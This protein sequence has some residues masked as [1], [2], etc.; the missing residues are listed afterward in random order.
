M[1]HV[2]SA[3]EFAYRHPPQASSAPTSPGIGL[4][5]HVGSGQLVP[6]EFLQSVS[7]PKRDPND[8]QVLRRLDSLNSGYMG[9]AAPHPPP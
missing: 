8:E 9:P 4:S 2:P 3:S 1:T 5:P 7:C 6:L